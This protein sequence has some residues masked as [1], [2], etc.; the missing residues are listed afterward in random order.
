MLDANES[1][2]QAASDMTS[3]DDYQNRSSSTILHVSLKVI[4]L[5]SL[6]SDPSSDRLEGRE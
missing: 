1:A 4:A 2:S 3:G 5:I 6:C